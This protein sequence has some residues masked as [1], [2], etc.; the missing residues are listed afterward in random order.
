MPQISAHHTW[1]QYS[2][3][4]LTKYGAACL[5]TNSIAELQKKQMRN[6]IAEYRNWLVKVSRSSL[7]LEYKPGLRTPEGGCTKKGVSLVTIQGRHI[8]ISEEG[9]V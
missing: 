2:V 3:E 7:A 1:S 9:Y 4:G 8:Y 6:Q 5:D